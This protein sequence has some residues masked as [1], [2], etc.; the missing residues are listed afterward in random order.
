[1]EEQE[2]KSQV[3]YVLL[4]LIII[5][6]SLVGLLIY[7]L[8]KPRLASNQMEKGSEVTTVRQED[9][10]VEDTNLPD[11]RLAQDDTSDQTQDTG[12]QPDNSALYKSQIDED[13]NSLDSLDLSSP[14]NDLGDDKIE[15][16]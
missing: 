5:V 2:N 13:L 15:E 16:L 6:I 11:T 10:K 3:K 8:I 14:E 4:L 1:M 7:L 12:T 9:A